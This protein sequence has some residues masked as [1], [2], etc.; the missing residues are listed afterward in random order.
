MSKGFTYLTNQKMSVVVLGSRG[1]LGS[2]VTW[3][4]STQTKYTI[5]PVSRTQ[6]DAVNQPVANLGVF[7]KDAVCVIN[8]IGGIPQ[9]SYSDEELALLNTRFPLDLA[10]YCE[11]AGLPLLHISTNCVFSGVV[12][13]CFEDAVPDATD[14][15]GISKAQGEPS[16]AVVLRCSIIGPELGSSF[17][18]LEWFLHSN[19]NVNGYDD[20]YWNG[21]TTYELAKQIFAL[22]DRRDFGARIQHFYAANTLSKYKLLTVIA[23]EFKKPCMIAPIVKGKKFYTLKSIHSPACPDLQTQIRDLSAIWD[24]Y[25]AFW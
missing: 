23:A 14:A 5:V 13:N 21:L 20:H 19:G 3:Y 4:G 2:M 15:Y 22:I 18:L 12:G 9:K 6:Y 17:G 16:S 8:C 25:R 10:A 11:E 24:D 1:M 7:L